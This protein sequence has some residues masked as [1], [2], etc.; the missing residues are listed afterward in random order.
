[1]KH[2]T[3]SLDKRGVTC[4][5]KLL[6]D[7]APRT[8]AAVWDALPLSAPVFHGKYA[9]NEI[10]TLLPGFG[11]DPGKENTT[12]TPIPGDVCAFWFS[13]A[14]LGSASHGYANAPGAARDTGVVDLAIF[15]E[16]NNLLLNPDV[17]WVPGNV[18]ATIV[19]GLDE[20]AAASQDMW[21]NGVAGERFTF[22]R[23]A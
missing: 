11:S 14:E 15:Y 4:V 1:M 17:G 7:V 8:C 10:Y 19:D 2:I 6:D 20:I 3:V 16:R 18:F 13:A 23:A 22:A 5:A 21:L 9:R 12:I